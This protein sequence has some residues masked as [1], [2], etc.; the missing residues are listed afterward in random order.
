MDQLLRVIK[1][2][3]TLAREN[4]AESEQP[5]PQFQSVNKGPELLQ[6]QAES[7]AEE[8]IGSVPY[9]AVTQPATAATNPV[10]ASEMR[11]A[12]VQEAPPTP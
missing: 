11:S 6:T 4:A 1:L 12:A 3:D 8:E 2:R 10:G 7:T 5:E 9:T